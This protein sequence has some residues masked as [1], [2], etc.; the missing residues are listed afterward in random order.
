MRVE[1]EGRAA[2]W[3]AGI[4][5]A[6]SVQGQTASTAVMALSESFFEPPVADNQKVSLASLSP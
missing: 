5:A 3:F 4:L 1:R 6:L 2:A